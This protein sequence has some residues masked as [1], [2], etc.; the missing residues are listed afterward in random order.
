M[1]RDP[2]NVKGLVS[3]YLKAIEI[4]GF[5][6]FPQKTVLTFEKDITA[7]VGP[8][9]SGKSNI[10][11]AVRWVM[12]EQSTKALRGGK[13]E[14]VIFGGTE[15]RPQMGFA[16]VSLILD[17]SG[18]TFDTEAS[19]VMI[20]R[21]Y[22]RSG[23]SE[24]YIN[25]KSCRLRDV[26]ELLMDTGLGREGYS[27][28]GQGRIDEI[29]SVK[30]TDR[31]EIFEEAAGISR[32]RHRKEESQKKLQQAEDNLLR[33]NDKISEL[34]L[35]VEPLRKQSETAKKYLV[36]RDEL[37]GYEISVWMNELDD[38]HVRA[39]RYGRDFDAVSAE[40]S[41]AQAELDVFYARSE[42]LAEQSREK[43][44]QSE[45]F[46]EEIAAETE[47][48]NEAEN[49]AAV[50]GATARAN[51]ENIARIDDEIKNQEG[52]S[53]GISAQIEL[54]RNRLS[55]IAVRKEENA[56]ALAGVDAETAE[57][58]ATADG[59]RSEIGSLIRREN[60]IQT[61]LAAG[62]SRA[63]LL[64]ENIAEAE[65]RKAAA[66]N[67][68]NEAQKSLE[69]ALSDHAAVEK[70][71]DQTKD[72]LESL[73]N[74]ISGYELRLNS[75]AERAG[76]AESERLRAEMDH[77]ALLSRIALLEEMEKD[78]AGYSKAV[79]TVM[80]ESRR[81][82]LKGVCG[83]VGELLSTDAG[84]TLAIETALGGAMQN[85]IV[86]TDE[87]GK[88]AINYLKRLDGGR[89]TFLP[90]STIRG[91]RIS[92]D[93]NNEPGFEGI[94][95]DL[96][97]FD[98]KYGGIYLSLLGRTAVTDNLDNA[99]RLG[100]KYRNRFRIVTLDGQLVNAGGS[101]T[102]GSAS[103]SAGILSRANEL[104]RLKVTEK[105]QKENLE[106]AAAA[107]QTAQRELESARSEM[108]VSLQEKRTAEDSLLR[109]E[110]QTGHCRLVIETCRN[111]ISELE[112]DIADIEAASQRNEKEYNE[113]LLR[114]DGMSAELEK[115]RAE[116][117]E[118]SAGFE[119]IS[120]ALAAIREKRDGILRDNA[121]L[122]AEVA[123]VENSVRELE[124]L[125][126]DLSGGSVRQRELIERLK[127]ENDEIARQIAKRRSDAVASEEKI[128]AGRERLSV[129]AAE[130][131]GLEGERVRRDRRLQEMN[132]RVLNLERESG[133]LE[134]L[135]L[136]AE[137]G[138]KQII[139]RLWDTYE[140]S[141][142]AAKEQMRQLDDMGEARNRIAELKREISKLGT[143]NI[144]AIDE[145][146]RV[147]ARYTYLTD[148]RAD[149]EKS[150]NELNVIIGDIT[151]EMTAIFA[152]KFN[153][154]D[155]SF[156]QTF[157]ELFGG[158]K[159]ALELEDKNDILN[160]GIEI[161]VQPPGKSLKTITLLSGGEKAFVAIALY[162]AILR[163]R[164]TPFVVMDEI[165][166]A[167]DE[168]NN[169]RFAEYLRNFTDKTQFLVITH[170][171]RTMEEADVL[172][173]VTMQ[174]KGISQIINIDLDE[175]EKTI[176]N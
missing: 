131:M 160:C 88:S 94:A 52:R 129:I 61:S 111:A 102:G 75:R 119:E 146:E 34:E 172:Y 123:A 50:L 58:A 122:D 22:Y 8:N 6:S 105:K 31:R 96:T 87:D 116:S 13:M 44:L 76:K 45:R 143:P 86:E 17:N 163:T 16:E 175:A 112:A 36:L 55:E 101:L 168:A 68:Y 117:A 41:S 120:D 136:S 63:E 66:E 3:L 26:N 35:Q 125:V 56:A 83:T 43:D 79:K 128:A 152:E 40:R 90:V 15:K 21:R 145:F 104:S 47:T 170:R 73:T 144:G 164:P 113:Y 92:E 28:I 165:E 138:A 82:I 49:A 85:I 74:M 12:G 53:S 97:V 54:H 156:R 100:K 141:R 60:E 71:L 162:F 110:T 153:E 137:L 142:S 159:A 77:S 18:H 51:E 157:T 29:L 4:Q 11:D 59:A 171:R 25:R 147:N 154:I 93:L 19:E 84:Y 70:E 158:G 24:Y 114:I 118:R 91:N 65:K 151:K 139:D 27:I 107:A 2:G 169:A 98:D 173:G 42:K 126:R 5:K 57:L 7:I 46:R 124:N 161:R 32:F 1:A 10:S 106:K 69:K 115:I 155:T 166:S 140:L 14:D 72:T 133:R 121:S 167:L 48:K 127:A 9:G 148:Q 30:S 99:I 23:D 176:L 174:E 109:L 149:V 130:K 33:I 135:K 134:Q 89:A 39:E 132:D 80:Q 78:Y 67:E 62:R 64:R 37:R 38:L 20:T 95:S 103:R 108:N 81:G 150:R